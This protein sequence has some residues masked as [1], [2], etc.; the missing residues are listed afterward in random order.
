MYVPTIITNIF[1]LAS[2]RANI[3]IKTGDMHRSILYFKVVG[4]NSISE[5][6][7]KQQSPCSNC[8]HPP[9]MSQGNACSTCMHKCVK[10]MHRSV[11]SQANV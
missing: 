5:L 11:T 10:C 6:K 3:H 1:V 4:D 7:S 8:M 2:T 9:V